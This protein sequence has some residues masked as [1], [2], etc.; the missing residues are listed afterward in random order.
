[1]INKKYAGIACNEMFIAINTCS[2]SGWVVG[3]P[4]G[5]DIYLELIHVHFLVG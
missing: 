4:K 5:E 2:F 3:D 1:M